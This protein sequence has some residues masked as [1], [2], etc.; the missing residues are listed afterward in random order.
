[1]RVS[2]TA[3][4]RPRYATQRRPWWGS[5]TPW[6]LYGPSL[7]SWLRYVNLYIEY[8]ALNY[9]IDYLLLLLC[10]L[11]KP[12]SNFILSLFSC[13]FEIY[14]FMKIIWKITPATDNVL[15]WE[16]TETFENPFYREHE[17]LATSLE[18]CG[19]PRGWYFF[20]I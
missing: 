17:S 6:P 18:V 5:R 14:I 15:N 1:M 2:I 9:I 20:Q 4:K 11:S 16:H 19:I 10:V 3:P 13:C 8:R 7:A 12:K